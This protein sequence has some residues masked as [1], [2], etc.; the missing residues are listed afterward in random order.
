MP[1]APIRVLIADDLSD[2][3]MLLR[4]SL[5]VAGDFDVVG[6]AADG[7]AC[8]A[9]TRDLNPDAVLL[10]LNMPGAGGMGII[11]ALRDNS[12]GTRVIVLSG[13]EASWA[14]AEALALGADAYVS[15]GA[16]LSEVAS[17]VR[18]LLTAGEPG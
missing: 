18:G 10:D 6:E 4:A 12:P 16:V 9:L 14:E 2:M 15:K 1:P 17:V 3:R 11:T 8:L 7:Q 13:M 5:D